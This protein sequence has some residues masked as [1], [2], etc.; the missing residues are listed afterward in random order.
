MSLL[1]FC[2]PKIDLNDVTSG[3]LNSH[4][5]HDDEVFLQN[6]ILL[7]FVLKCTKFSN[8]VKT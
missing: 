8:Y 3:N 6:N 7:H 1:L 2:A 4:K 5:D